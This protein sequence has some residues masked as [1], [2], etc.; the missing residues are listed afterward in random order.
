MWRMHIKGQPLTDRP[1]NLGLRR[2]D[3]H[4]AAVLACET[5]EDLSRL[6]ERLKDSGVVARLAAAALEALSPSQRKQAAVLD[7][8][9]GAQP[10]AV[11]KSANA[12]PGSS[13]KGG[14]TG[15]A[16]LAGGGADGRRKRD[17]LEA[18]SPSAAA[19]RRRG[20]VA[21]HAGAGTPAGLAPSAAAAAAPRQPSPYG[22]IFQSKTRWGAQ[23]S[24]AN[25]SMVGKFKKAGGKRAVKTRAA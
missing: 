11:A 19:K 7:G 10:S 6:M 18:P 23:V 15:P 12:G 20:D 9:S 1:M 8:R 14:A 13:E 21:A 16:R 24:I 5:T 3:A 2:Y 4:R 17:E 22:G 25:R